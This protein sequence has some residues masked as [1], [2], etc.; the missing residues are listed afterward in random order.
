MNTQLKIQDKAV[1]ILFVEDNPGDRNLIKEIFKESKFLTRFNMARDGEEALAFLRREGTFGDAPTPDLILLDLNLPK[2]DGREVLAEIKKDPALRLIPVLILT[3]SQDDADLCMAS[4]S[5]A[6]FYVVK[7]SG[8]E[9]FS[10]LLRHIEDFLTHSL[11]NHPSE[12]R[13][14][15]CHVVIKTE[16]EWEK[17][18]QKEPGADPLPAASGEEESAGIIARSPAMRQLMN[19][20]RT[21]AK[22]NSTVLLT[23]ESGVGK[24]KIAKFIHD[25]SAQ[26][27]GPFIAVNCG[28]I[29]DSLM[30]SELFGH[31]HGAFTGSTADRAGFFE[32]ANGGILFLDEIGEVSPSLQ[33]KLLRVLQEK[34]VRR[35][36][37]NRSRPVNV[38]IISATNKDL[39]G[40]VEAKRFREDMFYRLKVVEL[41]VPP[42]RQ[43]QEDILPLARLFLNEAS[44][45]M[46]RNLDGLSASAADE[47][48][49][50]HWPGNVRELENVMERAAALAKGSRV[51]VKDLSQEIT[52][53]K[54]PLSDDGKANSLENVER[55]LILRTLEKTKGNRMKASLA[56][57]M[58]VATLYRKLKMYKARGFVKGN[59]ADKLEG[60][61]ERES[62]GKL[63]AS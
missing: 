26:A 7:P 45:R 36:G 23:G 58:G 39:A 37:E 47:L 54:L 20:A 56:L 38:R 24:E 15:S 63:G 41:V 9:Y 53:G 13:D 49:A 33:V 55:L 61:T 34:E 28:A 62:V 27:K 51:T 30:E 42:L 16:E 11:E 18:L 46:K 40:E 3:G 57:G 31:A 22:I 4:K 6:N 8:A 25:H 32:A 21:I 5:N 12:N 43:R 29:T 60:V 17:A 19:M 2:K 35:V 50:Y 14:I 48:L 52:L 59:E 1:E 44:Y 10:V